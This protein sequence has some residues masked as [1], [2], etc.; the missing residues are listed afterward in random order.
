MTAFVPDMLP[1]PVLFAVDDGDRLAGDIR[2]VVDEAAIPDLALA[3]F[4]AYLADRF[5]LVRPAL[6]VGLRQMAAG[7]VH[8]QLAPQRDAVL[9]HEAADIAAAAVA[10]ALERQGNVAG[11]AVVDLHRVDIFRTEAGHVEDLLGAALFR[12]AIEI[13]E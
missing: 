12:W 5:H 13:E 1:D 10:V 11:E 7:G 9:R 4:A 8:R 2:V 6:H 3:A